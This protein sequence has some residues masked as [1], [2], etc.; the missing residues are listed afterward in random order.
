MTKQLSKNRATFRV[1]I[2]GIFHL[3]SGVWALLVGATA[4]ESMPS[5]IHF[6]LDA[7]RDYMFKLSMATFIIGIL[8]LLLFNFARVLAIILA[9]WNL[10]AAPAFLI[11]WNI[12]VIVIK[13][14]LI[15]DSW[16]N[17]WQSVIIV[18]II[19]TLIRI[20]II[21]M[22]NVSKAGYVFLK[23]NKQNVHPRSGEKSG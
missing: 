18:T 14:F 9:W 5:G 4:L 16:F 20:Y 21:R 22:L 23:K 13:K 6:L 11:W 19:M 7:Y 10:F 8:L 17:L 3:I 15:T 2:I 1:V 12:Y